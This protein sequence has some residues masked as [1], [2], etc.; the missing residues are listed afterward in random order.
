MKIN[1]TLMQA[2]ISLEDGEVLFQSDDDNWNIR[3]WQ[4]SYL[5]TIGGR[6]LCA[7]QVFLGTGGGGIYGTPDLIHHIIS[8]D[9]DR[10]KNAS[11]RNNGLTPSPAKWFKW[12]DTTECRDDLLSAADCELQCKN[13]RLTEHA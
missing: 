1:T 7:R 2:I 11:L 5:H 4:I 13:P 12:D 10:R 3:S 6:Q 8:N 9:F